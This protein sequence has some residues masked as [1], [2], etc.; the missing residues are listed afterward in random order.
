MHKNALKEA[1]DAQQLAT[2]VI[3][4]EPLWKKRGQ[5]IPFTS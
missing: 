4:H 3:T 2:E 5:T 1:L